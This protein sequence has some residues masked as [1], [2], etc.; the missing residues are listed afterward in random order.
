[1]SNDKLRKTQFKESH[2][3]K[4]SDKGFINKNTKTSIAMKS[5]GNTSIAAGEY[6]QIKLDKEL[7]LIN[8]IS[9][10]SNTVT[11]QKHIKANDITINNHKLNNQLWELTD[12]KQSSGTAIGG[13]TVSANVLVKTWEPTLQKWVLMRRQV[14]VPL[15]SNLLNVPSSP[16]QYGIDENMA[17]D[18]LK[19]MI[20]SDNK[21][22]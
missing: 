7:G 16:E 4:S 11:V 14:R 13:L 6:G 20:E 19:Y 2:L 9:L 18:V 10:Q 22:E 1:M 15:F 8:Q 21:E 12:F 3:S 5:D 17:K